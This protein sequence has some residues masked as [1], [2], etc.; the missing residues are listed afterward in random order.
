MLIKWVEPER[1]PPA[2]DAA[3]E[4]SDAEPKAVSSWYF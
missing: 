3:L 1:F 2:S 4:A